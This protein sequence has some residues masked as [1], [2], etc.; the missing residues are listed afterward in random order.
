[1]TRV[2]QFVLPA[3]LAA[4]V[5]C[6]LTPWVCRLARRIGALDIPGPRK[7]HQAPVPRLGGVAVVAALLSVGALV[8]ILPLGMISR[9]LWQPIALGLIPVLVVSFWDDL[10]SQSP[11][12]KLAGQVAG[13]SL[14]VA[15]GLRLTPE[16][17]LFGHAIPL[18]GLS[19]PLS[20]IWII[21]VT[22]AFNIVDGLDGLSAGLALISAASL[23]TVALVSHNPEIASVGVIVIGALVGF[24]P[25][26]TYPARVFLGDG[27]AAGMGFTLACLALSGGLRLP[28]G[29]AV[30][31]PV[32]AM[33][34]PVADATVSVLRRSLKSEAKAWRLFQADDEHIHHRLVRLGLHHRTAVLTLYGAALVAGT[35]G[36]VSLFVTASSAALL[37]GTALVATLLGVGRLGYDEFALFRRG[38]LLKLYDAPVLKIGFFRVFVDLFF[39]AGA[40]LMAMLLSHEAWPS[41][42]DLDRLV[43]YLPFVLPITAGCFWAFRLYDRAWRFAGIED[44]VS[45]FAAVV[46]ASATSFI[47]IRLGA[48]ADASIRLFVSQTLILLVIAGA[49]R[50]SFRVFEHWRVRGRR[51]GRRVA[52]Y[53]A[54][55]GGM[56]AIRELQANVSLRLVPVCFIDDD[57]RKL[58]RSIA[59]FPVLGTC[60]DIERIAREHR[61]DAILV[62]TAKIPMDTLLIAADSCES[63]G[64]E[65]LH[66]SVSVHSFHAPATGARAVGVSGGYAS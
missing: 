55:I 34:V 62:A 21:G 25:Y 13:A 32:F 37:L 4:L 2:L 64:V 40:L 51:D 39:A 29:L 18:G 50:A 60:L 47:A 63:A 8:C 66:F 15:S 41:A 6:L 11:L 54:G 23:S 45:L 49:G 33:G 48:D 14:V 65:L 7:L 22:N 3:V 35:V 52:V 31:V 58:G 30:L 42:S 20:M 9:S 5:S 16:V 61:L 27:G 43:R 28:A 46:S 36:I 59:G 24:L 19:L 26:N 17:H 1:V 53:G 57:P 12:V 10:S 38:L 44:V 56:M